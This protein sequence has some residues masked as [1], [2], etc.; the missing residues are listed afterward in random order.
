MKNEGKE[1]QDVLQPLPGVV[2][3]G[4]IPVVVPVV[5]GTLVWV[6][7]SVGKKTNSSNSNQRIFKNKLISNGK[8]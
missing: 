7:A 5:P 3:D 6:G 4:A 8:K 2:R 1:K